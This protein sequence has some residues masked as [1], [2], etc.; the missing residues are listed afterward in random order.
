MEVSSDLKEGSKHKQKQ[1][2]AGLEPDHLPR[3]SVTIER[4]V[5]DLNQHD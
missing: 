2:R 4:I 5:Y 3:A 1:V